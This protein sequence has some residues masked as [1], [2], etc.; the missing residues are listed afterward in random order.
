MTIAIPLES[1]GPPGAEVRQRVADARALPLEERDRLL[2]EL[3]LEYRAGNRSLWAPLILDFM[4]T[5]IKIRVSRYRPEGPTMTIG[6][7]YQQLVC[8]L[9]EDSLSIPLTG[10]ARLERRL[11]LRSANRVSRGLQ[12]EARYQ[13]RFESLEAW[14][15]EQ[16]SDDEDEEGRI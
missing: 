16:A 3:V 13:Q 9:L 6:D 2:Y 15:E 1:T 14:A 7:V 4:A 5:S 12:R 8:A 10:P 11:L